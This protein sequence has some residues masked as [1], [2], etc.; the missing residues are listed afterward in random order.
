MK[1]CDVVMN[2]IWYDPRVRK[3]IK[4]YNKN[5]FEICCVGFK[6]K[7]YD[8]KKIED[9]PCAV[10]I[11]DIDDR[12]KGKLKGIVAKVYR[13]WLK[14]RAVKSAIVKAK[15]QIIHA[16]DL[17]ALIP[18]YW[19]S[20]ILNCKLI[21]DSHEICAKNNTVSNNKIYAFLLGFAEKRICKKINRMI[22]V[23]N[24]A[25]DYFEKELK[26]ER[27]VVITNCALKTEQVISEDKNEGFEILNH[28]QFY[29]GRGYD[30]MME[31][32]P[33]IKEY[34]EIKLAIRGM[35]K[36]EQ[37]LRDRKEELGADNFFFYPPVH[38]SELIEK[39]SHSMVGVAMTEKL[40]LNFELSVSNKLFEYLAAGLPVIMSDIAEHRYLNEK[41]NI[42]VV[43]KEDTPE[44][45]A[46]AVIKLYTDKGFYAECAKNAKRLSNEIN[47]ENEFSKL[48]EIEQK[49]LQKR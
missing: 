30:I 11:A 10:T 47:W 32:A 34:P 44:A 45:F 18:A 39:A 15:P 33:L 19:A 37:Q 23:S 16:N 5:N 4:E 43:L 1:I 24:A 42:G 41:Y 38:V 14:T 3:Q 40:C 28:G 31:A 48:I 35:G 21:Y 36:M 9:I 22:C 13:E 29:A 25:A 17:D 26:V 20:K 7:R 12:F 27:P 2:S 49:L 6:C 46:E 8:E